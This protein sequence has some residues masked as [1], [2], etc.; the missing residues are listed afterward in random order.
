MNTA[1]AGVEERKINRDGGRSDV[2]K[3]L[4]PTATGA[5]LL[6]TGGAVPRSPQ[7]PH[8]PLALRGTS[9]AGPPQSKGGMGGNAGVYMRVMSL[10]VTQFNSQR[11][12]LTLPDVADL[13]PR[14]TPSDR[15]RRTSPIRITRWTWPRGRRW[16]SANRRPRNLTSPVGA[17]GAIRIFFFQGQGDVDGLS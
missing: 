2:R 12:N 5:E 15:V 13:T 4:F 8:T 16:T 7:S 1:L 11:R 14:R 3:G 17:H 6:R 9:P 10:S